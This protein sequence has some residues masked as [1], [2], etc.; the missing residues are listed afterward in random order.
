[1]TL[2]ANKNLVNFRM[3]VRNL[4]SNSYLYL[5]NW[6]YCGEKDITLKKYTQLWLFGYTYHDDVMFDIKRV[7]LRRQSL[8][9]LTDY[10]DQQFS[11]HLQSYL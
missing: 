6:F 7:Y 1:M 11:K 2:F 4:L 10:Q 8:K 9:I 3:I 5:I